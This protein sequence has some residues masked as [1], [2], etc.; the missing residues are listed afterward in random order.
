MLG[1]GDEELFE[2]SSVFAQLIIA[3]RHNN[4]KACEIFLDISIP[5]FM[6]ESKFNDGENCLCVY[7]QKKVS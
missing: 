7:T 4:K 5:S 6:N 3:M 2:E 1:T